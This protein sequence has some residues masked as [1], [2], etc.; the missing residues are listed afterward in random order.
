MF[1]YL[2]IV[3]DGRSEQSRAAAQHLQGRVRELS[4]RWQTAIE[5]PGLHVYHAGAQP[6]SIW[7]TLLP[8]GEGV[9]LGTL[10]ERDQP[11]SKLRDSAC[12]APAEDAAIRASAGRHLIEHYWGRY[13]AFVTSADGS[14]AW[15]LRD[16]TAGL[17]CYF[18]TIRGVQVFF[19]WTEDAHAIGL[20]TCSIN[21]HY[22]S[23]YV[24]CGDPQTRAT[25]IDAIQE[26]LG[27][28]RI[29]LRWGHLSASEQLW[30]ATHIARSNPMENIDDAVRAVRST[31]EYVTW[32][33][34]SCYSNIVHLLSGGLDSSIVLR[35]LQS[36]PTL[37]GISCLN[38]FGSAAVNED[39]RAL[40]RL[41]HNGI[42]CELIERAEQ[43]SSVRLERILD[44]ARTAVPLGTLY[45]AAT[46]EG[47]RE[48][49][50][51]LGAGAF[52]TGVGG[53][54]VFYQGPVA[55]ALA[56]HLRRH[57]GSR[58]FFDLALAMARM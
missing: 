14:N 54:A 56:D 18:A 58:G 36:A 50:S 53:D 26:V 43:G 33:W 8:D 42:D 20:E 45:R 34:A 2:A 11:P 16:P 3:W 49:A 38:Y 40:A 48:L 22:V 9:V 4:G 6:R 23:R 28:E 32:A 7:P 57:R 10:F 55:L 25:G 12:F 35:C 29:E 1:R 37:P 51:R 31:T 24:C 39:E 52:F 21:W 13:V 47:E 15:I 46:Q 5:L 17:P 30:D 41:A 44:C 27:G 19:S